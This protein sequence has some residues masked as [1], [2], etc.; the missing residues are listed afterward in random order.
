MPGPQDNPSSRPPRRAAGRLAVIAG[1]S[2]AVAVALAAV[3]TL[4]VTGRP[5]QRVTMEQAQFNQAVRNP[6]VDPG[7]T[8]PGITA[9]AFT[10]TDQFGQQVSLAQ[11]RGK[12]LVVAF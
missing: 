7:T 1:L 2:T 9:P 6:D 5:A 4:M 10:L 11:F 8:L 12:V 3:I